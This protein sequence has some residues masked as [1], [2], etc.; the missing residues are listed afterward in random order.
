MSVAQV[1]ATARPREGL[2]HP[3]YR[4]D[5][6]G[7]RAVAVVSVVGFHAFPWRMQ[8]GFVGVDIFFVISGFLISTIIFE[9]LD[10]QRF[11]FAEFYSRRV[12]RIFP[13]LL[14]M[15]LACLLT[16]WLEMLAD[17]LVQLGKHVAGGAGFVSNLLLWREAGYFDNAS[18][19]KPLLHLWSLGIEEQFYIFWP[20]LVWLA[21]KGHFNFLAMTLVVSLASFAVNVGTVSSDRVAAFYSPLSR[22]WELMV[23]GSLAY[24]CLYRTDLYERYGRPFADAWSLAGAALIALALVLLDRD[25]E[26]PGLWALLPTVGAACLIYAGPQARL[27]RYVL[28][29]RAFVW[30]GLI[31][32]PL[33][34][35]HWPLLSFARV[36]GAGEQPWPARAGL[37]AAA[38]VLAALSYRFVERPMR[39]GGH[40][41]AKTAGLALAMAAAAGAGLFVDARDGLE[42]QAFRTP[43]K[44]EFYRYFADI[45][46]GRWILYFEKNFRHECN[47]YPRVR[48]LYHLG[49]DVDPACYTRDAARPHAVFVWGDS[50]AQ[51]LY[52]GLRDQLPADW[53]ILQIASSGCP[54]NVDP[55][56]DQEA[57]CRRSNAAA[58]DAI[59]RASP[60]VVVVAQHQGHEVARM[61]QIARE[62]ERLGVK[63]IVFTGPAPHWTGDLPKLIV[64]RM[65]EETPERT[66]IGIDRS[67]LDLNESLERDFP[68]DPAMAYVDI[69]GL[70]CNGQGCLTRL[71]PD[72]KADI[73]SWDWGHLTPLASRFL[74]QDRL[75]KA[76]LEAS[77]SP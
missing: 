9:N 10:R 13:A 29:H 4:P 12:R 51:M 18:E 37:V 54:A 44:S 30:V 68:R 52:V 41:G 35:W 56:G 65:W 66:F 39:L 72:R 69:I 55:A 64:R 49:E 17:E 14:A 67:F 73:V 1:A 48:K 45:P 23:G 25:R 31:S 20:L 32:F 62:L 34:L 75:A 5:I 61:Q 6:D 24:A 53:Q 7:L 74:A 19:T 16:G 47:F 27:N 15:L 38:F 63:R 76:I 26:F 57:Y 28:S 8:G 22:F 3:K 2:S 42:G 58:R 21:W 46:K 59:A 33:Y 11:S 36:I 60:D 71:G 70:F 50:H 40:G 77:R 43:D